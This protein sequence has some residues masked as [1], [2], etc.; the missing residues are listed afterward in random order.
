MELLQ[1]LSIV[2]H[3]IDDLEI[4]PTL[5]NV[6]FFV[7]HR[8]DDLEKASIQHRERSDVCHRVDDLE[9]SESQEMAILVVRHRIDDLERLKILLLTSY[10]PAPNYSYKPPLLYGF[11]HRVFQKYVQDVYLQFLG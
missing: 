8:I 1:G 2:C 5:F 3:R 6:G 4:K 10:F 9:I 7:R 11:P